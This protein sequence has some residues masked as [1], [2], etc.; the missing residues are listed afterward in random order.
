MLTCLGNVGPGLGRLGPA[1]NFS[2]F[3]GFSKVVMSLL[4][5]LGRLELMP[6]LVMLSPRMWPGAVIALPENPRIFQAPTLASK[7]QPAGNT[8]RLFS[9]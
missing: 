1:G 2:P 7:K 8:G 4:M 5:L 3:S 9:R 6:I